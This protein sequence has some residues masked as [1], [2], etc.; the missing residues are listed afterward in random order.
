[1]Q[2]Y[3]AG[4][5]FHGSGTVLASGSKDNTVR[6]WSP[7]NGQALKTL[8][9]HTGWVQGLVFL[10]RGTRLASVSADQT[11]RLWDLAPPQK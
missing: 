9:G 4:A 10:T 8:E 6:L 3:R 7:A 5:A 1:M 11:V 2:E